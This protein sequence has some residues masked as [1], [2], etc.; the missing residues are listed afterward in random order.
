MNLLNIYFTP[1]ATVLVVLAVYLSEPE[2]IVRN[3]SFGLLVLSLV[4]NHW[5]SKNTYRF[6]G[7]T[8]K[9]K[10]IQVWLT[11]LWSAILAY[12]LIP[13]WAPTW[14]LLTMPAV[15]AAMY[16]DRV[17]TGVVGTVCGLTLLAVYWLYQRKVGMPLGP[18]LWGQACVH[19]GFIPVLGLFV[20]SLAQTALRLRDLSAR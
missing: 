6:I 15:T 4:V 17:Q 12:L 16:Q 7:W 5:L 9:I 18:Q 1:F 8:G 2:K 13:Y 3:L 14:L 20:H 10:I 11:F 19:A